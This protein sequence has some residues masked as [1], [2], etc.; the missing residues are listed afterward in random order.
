MKN[1]LHKSSENIKVAQNKIKEILMQSEKIS[2][3]KEN[4]KERFVFVNLLY[5]LIF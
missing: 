3:E 4:L 1:N 2:K 5:F